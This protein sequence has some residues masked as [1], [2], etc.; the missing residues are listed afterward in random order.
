MTTP[1]D[2]YRTSR[3]SVWRL[4][5]LQEYAPAG[6]AERRRVFWESGELPPPGPGKRDSLALISRLR[7][8]GVVVGRVHVVDR[9]ISPYLV[10][11]FAAY[12]ENVAAVEAVWIADRSEHP[13]LGSLTQ[14]CAVFDH[15]QAILFGYS[16]DG[17]VLTYEHATD[18]AT[19]KACRDQIALALAVSV[20]LEEFVRAVAAR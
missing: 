8:E 6:D 18:A 16:D 3:R 20:P 11:E 2:L 12:A 7:G 15:E 13:E 14:D 4:E 19:V 17:R 5:V 9:P 1:A 10:Y